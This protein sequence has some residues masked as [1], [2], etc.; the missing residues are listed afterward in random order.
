MRT[1]SYGLLVALLTGAVC[2]AQVGRAQT[3]LQVPT[4]AYPTIQKALDAAVDGTIVRVGRGTYTEDFTLATGVTVQGEETAETFLSGTVDAVAGGGGTLERFTVEGPAWKFSRAQGLV[5]RNCVVSGG[6]VNGVAITVENSTDTEIVNNVF[7]DNGTALKLGNVD[8]FFSSGKVLAN[9]FV[10]NGTALLAPM[11]LVTKSH[12]LFAGNA[13]DEHT[14]DAPVFADSGFVDP[15]AGDFHLLA[16]SGCIDAVPADTL[17]DPDGSPADCGAY[18]GPGQDPNP[19][20]VTGLVVTGSADDSAAL[21][22]TADANYLVTG[23]LLHYGTASGVYD[24]IGAA[25]GDSP[26]PVPG[27]GTASGSLSNLA[28]HSIPPPAPAGLVAGPGDAS[29]FLSWDAAAGATG[30]TVVYGTESGVYTTERDAGSSTSLA[31]GELT[32][33]VTYYLAVRPYAAST[34]FLAVGAT[35]TAPAGTGA[36][37]EGRLATEQ[38]VSLQRIEGDLSAEVTETPGEVSGYP[39]LDNGGFCFLR[40]LSPL[41]TLSR[42]GLGAAAAGML[43]LLGAAVS[44]RRGG[45]HHLLTVLLGT[46]WLATAG[47]ARAEHPRWSLDARAGAFWPGAGQWGEHYDSGVLPELKLGVGYRPTPRLEFGAEAGYRRAEGTVRTTDGGRPL[48]QGLDQTLTVMPLQGYALVRLQSSERQLLVPFLA[49]GLSSYLYQ[50]EVAGDRRA[51]GRQDGYHARAGVH[52]SLY[53]FDPRAADRSRRQYGLLGSGLTLEGQYARV[54]DF[55]A[56]DDDLGGW[57]LSVGLN[58]RF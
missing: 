10:G 23:Y 5:I 21:S 25:Q 43:L 33:G 17:A 49:A 6:P 52:L 2:S 24:G 29:I 1:H 51:R 42:G 8:G 20:Q 35:G 9:A 53:P 55:G 15:A 13:V 46:A 19:R 7:T 18:G 48:V 30:Y 38:T 31:L 56:A 50:H 54:D 26:V 47:A 27:G 57:S 41:R 44:A 45:G 16:G 12:N 4:A 37:P 40:T 58:L 3:V 22:W 32:N 34:Y 39:A 11:P 36:A 28:V 14:G